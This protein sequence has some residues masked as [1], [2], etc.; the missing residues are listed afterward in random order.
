MTNFTIALRKSGGFA[1]NWIE[2]EQGDSWNYLR[3]GFRKR[4]PP[5][6]RRATPRPGSMP[7]ARLERW[8][9]ASGAGFGTING[10]LDIYE[11]FTVQQAPKFIESIKTATQASSTPTSL[12]HYLSSQDKESKLGLNLKTRV[13]E[14]CAVIYCKG[15]ITFGI[16]AGVLSAQIAGLMQQPRLLVIDLSG[17]RMID[18]AGLGELVFVAASAQANQC[19]IKLVAPSDF[20]RQLL[21]LTG[22]TWVFEV[23]PTLGE[24][25]LAFPRTRNLTDRLTL[26]LWETPTVPS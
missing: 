20:I 8:F 4:L 16:E 22:L 3:K 12:E 24:A 5:R 10:A 15:R 6:S 1:K 13:I 25:T 26:P 17:V 9:P 19:S 21:E 23:Y 7:S 14:E 18:A 2:L 11:L